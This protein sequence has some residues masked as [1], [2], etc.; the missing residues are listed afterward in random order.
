MKIID[1]SSSQK[2]THSLLQN[3]FVAEK[4]LHKIENNQQYESV[5]NLLNNIS[6]EKDKVNDKI[7]IITSAYDKIYKKYNG[8]SLVVLILSSIA[9]L[10]EALRLS[11]VDY[12]AKQQPSINTE[13]ISFIMNLSILLSLSSFGINEST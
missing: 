8:I 4:L 5:I 11:I 12:I 6:N 2:D 7:F 3:E 13:T 9:T 1:M 10:F